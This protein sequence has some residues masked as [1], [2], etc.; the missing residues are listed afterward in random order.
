MQHLHDLS[1]VNLPACQVTIGSFDGVHR[2]HQVLVREMVDSARGE[3][4]PAVVL[5]FFPHPSVV[6][7]GRTPAFYINTPEEKAQLLAELGVEF[8]ITQ[9][10]DVELSR[11]QAGDFLELL[12]R[13][14]A[15]T[16]LWIGEDFALGH[17]REGNRLFLAKAARHDG[18][19][20]QVVAPMNV[21][22]EVVSSTRV[23]EALRS[24]DVSRAASYLGRPFSLPGVVVRGSARG[25]KLG[26]P[27]ANLSIW[28]ERAFPGAGV[29]ACVVEVAGKRFKAVTNIGVR[30]TF[31]GNEPS[32]VVETHILDFSGDLYGK[33]IRIEFI[34]RLRDERRFPGPEALLAQI[35]K[36][37]QRAREILDMRKEAEDD[38]KG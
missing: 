18:F 28:E 32:P 2:G 27:T 3:G 21:G 23:R 14:L 1:Q 34:V 7:R 4:L 6:L 5:T 26:I 25:A 24:G 31:E 12:R 29:Y 38:G 35:E 30:P 15:F 10:F 13:H 33:E 11:I 20:L 36:D 16:T 19:R 17:Q 22:G 37:I 8:V 9:R